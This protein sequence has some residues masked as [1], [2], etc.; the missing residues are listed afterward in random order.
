MKPCD[1]NVSAK[2]VG[3]IVAKKENC[4]GHRKPDKWKL[5][6]WRPGLWSDVRPMSDAKVLIQA[7]VSV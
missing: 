6:Q 3:R 5:D 4:W 2:I 1:E 7:A